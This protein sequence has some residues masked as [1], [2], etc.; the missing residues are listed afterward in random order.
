MGRWPLKHSVSGSYARSDPLPIRP[1]LPQAAVLQRVADCPPLP[2]ST[3]SQGVILYTDRGT[4]IIITIHS[5]FREYLFQKL[6][7]SLGLSLREIGDL[8]IDF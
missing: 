1:N 6:Q 5:I 3:G 8:E 4:A 2:P 7:A